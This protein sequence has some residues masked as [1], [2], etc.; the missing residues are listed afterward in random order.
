M[1]LPF[2]GLRRKAGADP[3]RYY[4]RAGL[5]KAATPVIEVDKPTPPIRECLAD[6]FLEKN[7]ASALEKRRAE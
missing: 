3:G 5:G 6:C 2:A 7:S 4:D 1:S